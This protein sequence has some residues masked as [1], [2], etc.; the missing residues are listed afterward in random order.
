M[1]ADG[2]YADAAQTYETAAALD[3]DDE[4]RPKLKK[5]AERKA[6]GQELKEQGEHE[7][8]AGDFAKAA[9]TFTA[10]LKFDPH[11]DEIKQELADAQR[12]AK[13]R[14]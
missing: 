5:K 6:K 11:N 14:A 13:A 7:A 10:A 8:A 4:T 12:K 3:P 1:F 9:E 2:E